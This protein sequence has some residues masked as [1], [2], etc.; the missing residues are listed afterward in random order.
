MMF[1]KVIKQ[2]IP[3]ASMYSASKH[4]ARMNCGEPGSTA[5]CP[6]IVS[7]IMVGINASVL[8]KRY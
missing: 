5:F 4:A 7:S 3:D 6:M 8:P 1:F 2:K